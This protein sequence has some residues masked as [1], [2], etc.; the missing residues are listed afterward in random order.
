MILKEYDIGWGSHWPM[1]QLEQQIVKNFLSDYYTNDSKTVV[2]NSVWYTGDYHQQVM[3]ELRELQPTHIFVVALLDPPIIQLNWFDELNCEVLGIGYYPGTGYIDYCALFVDHFYKPVDQNILISADVIDTPYMCLNRKPHQHRM[4]L[5]QGLQDADL[6]DR[7][8]VSMGGTP[9]LRLLE[10]DSEGQEIAPNGGTEQF[11]ITNDI[12][13]LGNLSNWQR[14]FVNIVTETIWDIEPSNFLSEKT[15]KPILGLRPFLIYAPN[16]G[17]DC[18]TSRGFEHY[19]NDFTDITDADLREPYNI[20]VFLKELCA[21]PS[22]YWQMKFAQLKEK[23]L[24]NQQRFKEY[25]A[26][27]KNIL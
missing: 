27:Q 13:S 21:Q 22:N 3:Q 26:Q 1:K 20:P 4:R 10:N 8:F 7:G 12:V 25:A 15:F 17:I 19:I 11:G 6:L 2:I 5:Y 16:G 9:P 18:L 24:Y 14:H 23:M